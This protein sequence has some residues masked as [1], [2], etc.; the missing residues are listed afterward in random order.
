VRIHARLLAA[1]VRAAGG[2]K[3]SMNDTLTGPKADISGVAAPGKPEEDR[4]PAEVLGRDLMQARK[5]A[6]LS[7]QQARR[8]LGQFDKNMIYRWESAK[9]TP[10]LPSTVQLAIAYRC[11]LQELCP[12]LWTEQAERIDERRERLEREAEKD[13]FRREPAHRTRK[14][15]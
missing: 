12:S 2:L 4:S 10:S 3:T 13:P 1:S 11:S 6:G 14:W 8:L 9:R 7:R 15:E 5:K